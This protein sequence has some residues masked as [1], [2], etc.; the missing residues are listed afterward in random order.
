MN[1]VLL[2]GAP[3]AGKSTLG[4]YLSRKHGCQFLSAGE[5]I[6]DQGLLHASDLRE[7]AA[8]LLERTLSGSGLLILEYAKDID[9]AY[10]LMQVLAKHGATLA[11]VVL[12]TDRT[13]SG[14]I[15]SLL[16]EKTRVSSWNRDLERKVAERTPK[17]QANAGLMIEFF[18]SMGILGS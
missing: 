15:R 6:R 17:W 10:I 16:Q 13:M 4:N 12:V 9:D 5:W 7:K 11:Q 8:A 1:I 2:I 14:R 3:G 18:S